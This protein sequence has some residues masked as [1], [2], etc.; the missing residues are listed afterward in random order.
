VRD[1]REVNPARLR[2][3]PSRRSGADPFQLSQ[4]IRKFGASTFGMPAVEVTEDGDGELMLNDGVTRAICIALLAPG[5][6]IPIEVIEVRSAWS[7]ARL[8]TVQEVL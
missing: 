8:K 6:T 4:Q 2:L 5:V 7:F 1:F 3:P